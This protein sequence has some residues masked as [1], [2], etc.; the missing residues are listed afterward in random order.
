MAPATRNNARS[1]ARRRVRSAQALIRLV[2][3]RAASLFNDGLRETAAGLHEAAARAILD[4]GE[5]L[6][7][8]IRRDLSVALRDARSLR[9]ASARAW[10]IGTTLDRVAAS[11]ARRPTPALALV[12][13]GS[14][15]V[16]GHAYR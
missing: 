7:T 1:S 3:R 4:G 11:L 6:P 12:R 2:R 8:S 16:P 9:S 5:R 14:R 15:P 13:S 10:R